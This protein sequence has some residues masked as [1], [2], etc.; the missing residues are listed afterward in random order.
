MSFVDALGSGNNQIKSVPMKPLGHHH[1]MPAVLFTKEE[2]ALMAEPFKLSLVGKFSFGRP[3]MEV[4]QKFVS[5]LHLKGACKVSLLDKRHVLIQLGHDEDY[6]RLWTRQSWFFQGYTMRIFKWNPQFHCNEESPIVPVWISLPY[7]PVHFM[8][9]QTALFSIASAIG[10]PLRVDHATATLSR[11]TVARVLVECNVSQPTFTKE[12][13]V[14]D[15]DSGFVQEIIIEKIPDYCMACKHLGHKEEKCY[16]ANP[17]LRPKRKDDKG[18]KKE[19][20]AM[21]NGEEFTKVDSPVVPTD[22]MDNSPAKDDLALVVYRDSLGSEEVQSDV[23]LSPVRAMDDVSQVVINREMEDIP[24]NHECP[25]TTAAKVRHRYIPSSRKFCSGRARDVPFLS[26]EEVESE[27]F[28]R[29]NDKYDSDYGAKVDAFVSNVDA[30]GPAYAVIG[31]HRGGRKGFGVG[32]MHKL[33]REKFDRMEDAVFRT[34]SFYD[35]SDFDNDVDDF[36]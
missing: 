33:R 15:E 34:G 11:P 22:V 3:S 8:K 30:A 18:K 19:K 20:V 10:N 1:G 36:W 7:L 5:T 14:G 31:K 12:V 4:I 26:E 9:C 2:I 32:K 24:S 25:R 17:S 13:W 28:Y 21:G 35:L 27:E 29:A 16:I 23:V 6:T